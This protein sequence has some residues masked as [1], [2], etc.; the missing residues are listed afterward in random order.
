MVWT[1]EI[2][3]LNNIFLSALVA[4]I[5]ILF[6]FWALAVKRMKGHWSAICATSLALGIAVVVY[7]M[8]LR[9]AYPPY[10]VGWVSKDV[11]RGYVDGVDPIT[12]K[13]LMQE[14]GCCPPGRTWLD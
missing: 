12:G 9:Y 8:P 3:P 6:L 7:G 11:L 1:M 5:P 13:P 14:M 10:P 2:N 4:A